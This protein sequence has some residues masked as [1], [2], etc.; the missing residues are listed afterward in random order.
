MSGL[1]GSGRHKAVLVDA[2]GQPVALR[3]RAV[4]AAARHAHR[5][6]LLLTAAH[7]IRKRVVGR[8]VIELAGRLVVP[9]A[10]RLAAVERHDRALIGSEQDDVGVVGIDPAVLIVLAARRAFEGRPRLAAV[11][12]L[13]RHRARD[14]HDVGIWSDAE[15][16]SVNRRRRFVLQDGRRS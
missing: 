12:R 7:A 4:V 2:D 3:D 14:D 10:P 15:S 6:A 16:A 11:N 9:G 5:S 1:S 13:P 8:H